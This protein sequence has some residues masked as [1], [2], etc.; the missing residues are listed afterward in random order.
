MC[1]RTILKYRLGWS[2]RIFRV[3]P[4]KGLNGNVRTFEFF[5]ASVYHARTDS[6]IRKLLAFV[7]AVCSLVHDKRNERWHSMLCM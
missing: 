3:A 7:S 1:G 6:D 2:E 4:V 5:F